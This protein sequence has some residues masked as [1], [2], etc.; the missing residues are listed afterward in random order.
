MT[1]LDDIQFSSVVRTLHVRDIPKSNSNARTIYHIAIPKQFAL[2]LDLKPG[3]P[4]YL[5]ISKQKQNTLMIIPQPL[6]IRLENLFLKSMCG[7]EVY[8]RVIYGRTHSPPFLCLFNISKEILDK[9]GIPTT[10]KSEYKIKMIQDYM[11]RDSYLEVKPVINNN[12]QT[13]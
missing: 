8:E 11:K 7:N 4:I 5:G 12:N 2:R 13:I 3:N 1:V 6:K 10:K 9:V